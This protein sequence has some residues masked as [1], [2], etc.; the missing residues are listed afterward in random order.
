MDV[1]SAA[2]DPISPT[3][4]D[5][6][7]NPLR[8]PGDDGIMGIVNASDAPLRITTGRES[9]EVL[10][11]KRSEVWAYRIEREGKTYV[12]PTIRVQ[13]GTN[14]SAELANGLDEE[15]TIHWHGQHVDWRMDGHPLLPVGPGAAYRYAY[16][17]ANRGGTYWYHPH[18]HG[19]SAGQTYSGLAGFFLVEDEDERRLSEALDLRL[20]QTDIPLLI[21]DKMLDEGGNFVYAPEPM[22]EEMG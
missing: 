19:T 1:S 17:V 7:T 21:Q 4:L 15:T 5:N 18:A 12:N 3:N 22:D 16:P 10:P 11:G 8:L 20:G 6:F 14:F 2:Y 9:L 13:T